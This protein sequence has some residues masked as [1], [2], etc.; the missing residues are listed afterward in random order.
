[1]PVR[2]ERQLR[3]LGYEP[4][5]CLD[6]NGNVLFPGQPSASTSLHYVARLNPMLV[7]ARELRPG[8]TDRGS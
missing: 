6:A 7:A 4:I 3:E 5:E 8:H 1:V 2:T